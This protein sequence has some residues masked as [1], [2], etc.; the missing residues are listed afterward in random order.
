MTP[1]QITIYDWSTS[2]QIAAWSCSRLMQDR[3]GLSSFARTPQASGA[4]SRMTFSAS[5][6]SILSCVTADLSLSI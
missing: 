2:V 6:A 4:R 3:P 1:R 5:P